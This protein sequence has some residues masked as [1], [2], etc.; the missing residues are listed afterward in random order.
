MIRLRPFLA[1]PFL[2]NPGHV[3]NTEERSDKIPCSRPQMTPADV[4]I[5]RVPHAGEGV[6]CIR[7]MT[8]KETSSVKDVARYFDA[9]FCISWTCR[10]GTLSLSSYS[11]LMISCDDG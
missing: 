7:M 10:I 1:N 11:L 5:C 6:G 3:R 9:S 2:A 8:E 4:S